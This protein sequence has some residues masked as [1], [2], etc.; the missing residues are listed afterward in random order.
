MDD[1]YKT[2]RWCRWNKNGECQHSGTF[3]VDSLKAEC[4]LDDGIIYEAVKEAFSDKTFAKLK[5]N[6]ESSL[7]KKKA[8]LF[9]QEFLQ[10][11]EDMQRDWAIAIDDAVSA[12]INY[13][14]E[15]VNGLSVEL[16]MKIRFAVSIGNKDGDKF[17]SF[18]DMSKPKIN[19]AWRSSRAGRTLRPMNR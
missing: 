5:R 13:E 3:A 1:F 7:S 18:A 15:G 6:L 16:A 4:R 19:S 10:E 17:C 11:L 12:K 2:C 14:L 8:N 9:Y